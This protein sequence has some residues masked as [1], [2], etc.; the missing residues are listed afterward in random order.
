MKKP[1]VNDEKEIKVDNY[2][3]PEHEILRKNSKRKNR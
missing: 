3:I 1:E 2:L